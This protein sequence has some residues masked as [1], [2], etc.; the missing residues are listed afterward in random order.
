MALQ[1]RYRIRQITME[2]QMSDGWHI[3]CNIAK[4]VYDDVTGEVVVL[5]GI[6][7]DRSFSQLSQPV[8]DTLTTLKGQVITA[9]QNKYG[10]QDVT[11]YQ[12]SIIESSEP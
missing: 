8:K 1:I 6:D 4:E 9:L 10:T 12:P 11:L 3:R 2:A 7:E 5:S